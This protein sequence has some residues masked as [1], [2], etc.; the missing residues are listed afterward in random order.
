M[1]WEKISDTL[2]IDSIM[3]Q[4]SIILVIFLSLFVLMLILIFKPDKKP[5]E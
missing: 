4:Y 5:P 1:E 2:G 3:L